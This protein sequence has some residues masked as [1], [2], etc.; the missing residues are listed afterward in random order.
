M[1]DPKIRDR[2][3]RAEGLEDR[4]LRIYALL[5]RVE[6]L[7][8]YQGKIMLVAF[9]GTHLPLLA[10]TL[11]LLLGTSI[12]LSAA[13]RLLAV[14]LVATLVGTALTLYAVRAL[15]APVSLSSSS[16]KGYLDERKVPELPTRY[17]DQAGTLMANVRYVIEHLDS[18]IRSLESLSGTDHL[19]G[20]LNRRQAEE[21]L[22]GEAARMHRSGGAL[23]VGVVDVNDFKQ[24]NDTYG[25]HAGDACLRHV[26]EVIRR[27][28]RESDWL[29]RWG[30][31]EFVL[32]LHDSSR[33]AQPEAVLQRIV[34]DLKESPIKLDR[35]KE[36][37]LSISVGAVR[38]S[39]EEDHR[40]LLAK[41]DAAMYEAKRD[42]RSWVLAV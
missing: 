13:L 40:E 18:T 32:A 25:H 31:D 9:L 8:S 26:A 27:N 6:F 11:Y 37:T 33:F 20:I 28:T 29:A 7:K 22:T 42:G 23:T 36:L 16:L 19:T 1:E 34:R 30:G 15:L 39:G 14:L 17:T 4:T 12:G 38:Y 35:D 10:L 2:T 3:G 24:I 41:A 21:R 5:S